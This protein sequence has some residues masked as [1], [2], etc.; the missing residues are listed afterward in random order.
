LVCS[1]Q[2]SVGFRIESPVSDGN[3]GSDY[4]R[5]SITA[6]LGDPIALKNKLAE[7]L[8]QRLRPLVGEEV[9]LRESHASTQN[10]QAWSLV[11][12]SQRIG[13]E[14][15]DLERAGNVDGALKALAGADTLLGQAETL[16]GSSPE[17][18]VVR[19]QLA[20]KRSKLTADPAAAGKLIETGIAYADSAIALDQRNADALELRG[21]L[22]VEPIARGFVQ[23]Q[24]QVKGLVELAEKDLRDAVAINQTQAGALYVLSKIAYLNHDA[25]QANNLAQRAYQADAYLT[26]APDI[27]WRL[28][29]T[30][31]DLGSFPAAQ[32]WC[33]LLKKRYPQSP[34]AGRCE[35]W[36]MTA[37]GT[38]HDPNEAWR[39]AAD[40]VRLVPPQQK[41]YI[42]REAQI[43]VAQ[44]LNRDN[45]PDSARR[46]L[47]HAR[48]ND[49]SIDPRGELV[50]Y[51][52]FVRAQLGD[53]KEAVDL[54]QKYL[55]DHPEHRAGFSLVNPWWWL[56]LQD[57]PR[58]KSLI[59]TG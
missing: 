48:T 14:A 45:Q 9:R 57:D 33:D 53:K 29:V 56:P 49:R 5:G 3:S 37:K 47:L 51:E 58:F 32:E 30:S 4:E 50:G 7:S 18:L 26:A 19:G 22:R 17:P 25:T 38:S 40:Y 44:V 21:T 27:L 2:F 41:E 59:A 55:T 16:D 24:H 39:R 23:D 35:L 36:I 15:E 54:L 1:S 8:A 20:A 11:Q 34:N 46:V 12:R 31:Y 10:P 52:A 42:T 6:P 13:K 28:Y 43:A